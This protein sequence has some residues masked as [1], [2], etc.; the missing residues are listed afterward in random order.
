MV[1]VVNMQTIEARESLKAEKNGSLCVFFA[2]NR[3]MV[4]NMGKTWGNED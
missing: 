3:T 1:N 2:M 4:E